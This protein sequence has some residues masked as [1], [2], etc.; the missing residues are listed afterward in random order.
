MVG[1]VEGVRLELSMF[2]M[3]PPQGDVDGAMKTIMALC[4]IAM[5]NEMDYGDLPDV[6][7]LELIELTLKM[8]DVLG[9]TKSCQS[10]E[11]FSMNAYV[12]DDSEKF[13]SEM[14]R[15]GDPASMLAIA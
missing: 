10:S 7:R 13:L 5:G 15:Y 14:A 3:R 8:F 6:K 2:M 12:Y 1:V 4:N 9:I 11:L